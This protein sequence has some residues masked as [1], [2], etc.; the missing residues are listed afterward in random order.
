MLVEVYEHNISAEDIDTHESK[1][2]VLL[3]TQMVLFWSIASAEYL[4]FY[5]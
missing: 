1:F 3:T 5:M 4:R 2:G